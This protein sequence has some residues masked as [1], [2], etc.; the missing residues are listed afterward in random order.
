[1]DLLIA[2]ELLG[3]N[4]TSAEELYQENVKK[5]KAVAGHIREVAQKHQVVNIS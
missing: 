2:T 1:M 4:E 3:A 5:T